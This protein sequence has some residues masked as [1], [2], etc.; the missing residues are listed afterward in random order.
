MW[1]PPPREPQPHT[2][3]FTVRY[4]VQPFT[5]RAETR[6]IQRNKQYIMVFG[7][8]PHVGIFSRSAESEYR[9]LVDILGEDWPV[10]AF[11]ITNTNYSQFCEEINR[12]SFGILYHSRN[13]GRVNITDVTDSL[14][15]V[16]VRKMS[17]ALGKQ[18]VITVI[19]DL[20]DSGHE[21]KERILSNQHSL[22]TL[23][24]DIVLFTSEEKR[25]HK[26]LRWKMESIKDAI[27]GS[28]RRRHR[29]DPGEARPTKKG[30]MEKSVISALSSY[31]FWNTYFFR[32][33][34]HVL[35][36]VLWAAGT[37][38]VFTIPASKPVW[39]LSSW[40]S[41]TMSCAITLLI[42]CE[43]YHRPSVSNVVSS[44]LWATSCFSYFW[45]RSQRSAGRLSWRAIS[46]GLVLYSFW[47]GWR[48]SD[49]ETTLQ[50]MFRFV[51]RSPM[52][53]AATGI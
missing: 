12:C 18:R 7:P 10:V 21:A 34:G 13:R 4:K 8:P 29:E 47:K 25:N 16:E 27:A 40:G 51:L 15:D 45:L 35:L 32:D 1:P 5:G 24:R 37:W 53:M 23:T 28:V 11:I 39:L 48:Q 31:V 17:E 2:F 3:T 30:R 52:T 41:F 26:L 14:Y 50:Q 42:I 19:D 9:W 44:V 36:S 38:R 43:T 46:Y 20:D 49:A 33:P 6:E 22:R